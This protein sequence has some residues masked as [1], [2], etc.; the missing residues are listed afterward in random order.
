MARLIRKRARKRYST[1]QLESPTFYEAV[2]DAI[3]R[4]SQVCDC[5][6]RGCTCCIAADNLRTHHMYKIEQGSYED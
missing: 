6:G 1:G 3:I 2:E 5:D 4:L